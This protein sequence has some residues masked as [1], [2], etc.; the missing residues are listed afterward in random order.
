[1]NILYDN[2]TLT[3]FFTMRQEMILDNPNPSGKTSHFEVNDDNKS[4]MQKNGQELD[5]IS[6]TNV[7]TEVFII[8]NFE[9]LSCQDFSLLKKNGVMLN[10]TDLNSKFKE[11]TTRI[12]L[13]LGFN[14]DEE[15]RKSLNKDE[16]QIDIVLNLGGNNIMIL[17]CDTFS[18]IKQY[19]FCSTLKKLKSYVRVAKSNGYNVVKSIFIAPEF[20]DK[21]SE[22]CDIEYRLSLLTSR[23]LIKILKS[24]IAPV[25]Q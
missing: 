8:E 16:H 11:L 5:N 17:E 22:K 7:D 6:S 21:F 13:K 4:S 9:A 14:A 15:L 24:L 3:N 12:F 1:M 18:D 19:D 20:S 25:V 23:S 2:A 10:E